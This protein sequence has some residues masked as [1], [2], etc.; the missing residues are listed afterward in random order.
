M[1]TANNIY[2]NLLDDPDLEVGENQSR[3]EAA[4]IEANQRTRQ[5]MNNVQA[6]S[7]A[8]EP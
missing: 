5:Y 7:L 2:N 3:E 4:Q 6:L 8:N 1:T